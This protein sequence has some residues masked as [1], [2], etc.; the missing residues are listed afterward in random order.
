MDKLNFRTPIILNGAPDEF[1][2]RAGAE[3]KS[4]QVM[5]LDMSNAVLEELLAAARSGKQ[6]QISFGRTPML[7]LGNHNHVLDC[8][9]SNIRHEL[10]QEDEENKGQWEFAGLI[11]HS[12]GVKK[13]EEQSAGMDQA[14]EALKNNMASIQKEQ[15]ARTTQVVPSISSRR[16]QNPASSFN[17]D[18]S[19]DKATSKMPRD[20]NLSPTEN[21]TKAVKRALTHLLATGPLSLRDCYSRVRSSQEEA[22]KI[23][24]NIAKEDEAHLWQLSSKTWLTVEPFEFPYTK[25]QREACIEN[26]IRAFDRQRIDKEDPI[27]QNLLPK[28]DRNKGISLSKLK[29]QA[30]K[31]S[32]P[33][34]KPVLKSAQGKR[35]EKK[36]EKK[37]EKAPVAKKEEKRETKGT[38]KSREVAASSASRSE[39]Q[40]LKRDTPKMKPAKVTKPASTQSPARRPAKEAK[41]STSAKAL[42]NKPKNPSPLSLSPPVNASDFEESHPVHKALSAAV[43]PSKS[44]GVKNLKRK[45]LETHRDVLVKKARTTTPLGTPKMKPA[46]AKSTPLKRKSPDD[47][48]SSSLDSVPIKVRKM[49]NGDSLSRSH[50]TATNGNK[51]TGRPRSTAQ[52]SDDSSVTSPDYN[53]SHHQRVTL[54]EKFQRRYAV[55]KKRYVEL[56]ARPNGPTSSEREELLKQHYALEDMKRKLTGGLRV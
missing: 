24:G 44:N 8:R 12:L 53:M 7:R 46:T 27:W 56:Q 23:L 29:L 20:P 6:P 28:E 47:S 43:S 51:S 48:S 54:A 39:A 13:M 18:D 26:A 4:V 45:A 15:A 25:P 22:I 55:Y 49:A 14:L 19:D 1:L 3:S 5:Q 2:G 32:T 10:Y 34:L 37:S 16:G 35:T 42:L 21:R 11:S 41:P 52:V 50:G 38:P 31:V 9:P 30:P 40:S 36:V 33:N 17:P